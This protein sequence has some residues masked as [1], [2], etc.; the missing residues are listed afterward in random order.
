M[1]CG[2]GFKMFGDEKVKYPI[3]INLKVITVSENPVE[4]T[5]EHL[6]EIFNKIK[7]HYDEWSVRPSSKGKYISIT[8]II[9]LGSEDIMNEMYKEIKSVQGVIMA[10]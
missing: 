2:S 3:E 1:S 9:K 5:K 6:I 8:V 10:M 7:I 4:K